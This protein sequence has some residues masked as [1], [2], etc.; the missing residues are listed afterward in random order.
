MAMWN[1]VL[2]AGDMNVGKKEFTK[3]PNSQSENWLTYTSRKAG[4]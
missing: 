4:S 3:G 1:N 2:R